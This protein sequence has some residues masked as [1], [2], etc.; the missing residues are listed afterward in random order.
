MKFVLSGLFQLSFVILIPTFAFAGS[1][2][3]GS[4]Q[5]PAALAPN[6]AYPAV[7]H[8]NP[9]TLRTYLLSSN[10]GV[11]ESLNSVLSAKENVNSKRGALLPSLNISVF[12]SRFPN[13]ASA[14]VQVLL[15]FLIPSNWFN[16]DMSKQQLAATGYAYYLLELNDYASAVGLYETVVGDIELGKVLAKQ[17]QILKQISEY[18]H[19]EYQ[20]GTETLADVAQAKYQADAALGQLQKVNELIAQ[21]QSQ[22]RALLGLPLSV[23]LIFDESHFG[24]V[25]QENTPAA[26]I[27]AQVNPISAEERQFESL[28]A[29]A[30]DNKKNAIFSFLTGAA[31]NYNSVGS[32]AFNSNAEVTGGIGFSYIPNINIADLSISQLR[33]QQSGLQIQQGQT[34]E[35]ALDSIKSDR[36]QV[37]SANE[38][39]HEAQIFFDG[40]MK[41]YKLAT[42]DLLHAL[43][44]STNLIS[45]ETT[46]VNVKIDLDNQRL[47]L[48][49]I[50][51]AG[52]FAKVPTCAAKGAEK[53]G[54]IVGVLSG[55]FGSKKKTISVDQLC[56]ATAAAAQEASSGVVP[57]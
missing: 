57:N 27:L 42:V 20:I 43:Q 44:A 33:L 19:N 7:L 55:F 49:R 9:T 4:E 13:F 54:G 22:V 5:P 36:E 25:A 1:D 47:T 31:V 28:I 26:Q 24:Q 32:S 8:I 11:L 14:T 21:E 3:S 40:E 38:A 35:S 56:G 39:V 29:A 2:V 37:A 51:V 17:Y 46:A 50:L 53:S 41:A 15:P 18:V 52:E 16:L 6:P 23:Q 12:I 48:L 34:I 45:A 30:G 10:R